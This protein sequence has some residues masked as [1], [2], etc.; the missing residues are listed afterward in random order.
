MLLEINF[1]TWARATFKGKRK[2]LRVRLEDLVETPDD[3]G[4]RSLLRR[5]EAVLGVRVRA[6]QFNEVR[7]P[8][9]PRHTDRVTIRPQTGDA[10]TPFPRLVRAQLLEDLVEKTSYTKAARASECEPLE[11]S[12]VTAMAEPLLASLGYPTLKAE[13]T[14][15]TH[16]EAFLANVSAHIE[17]KKKELMGKEEA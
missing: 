9:A 1:H 5:L 13:P 11:Y 12:V 2:Y 15:D 6:A 7:P 4:R 14:T 8:R 17:K 10:L 3:A 16:T